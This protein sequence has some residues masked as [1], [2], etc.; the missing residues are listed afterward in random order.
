MAEFYVK[1]SLGNLTV[2]FNISLRYFVIKGEE[3][4]HLWTLEIGTTHE[5][6]N[7]N[8][9]S[10]KK[11][12]NIS[13]GNLD[14][15]IEGALADLCSQIDWSPLVADKRAPFVDNFSPS[16]SSVPITSNVEIII[17]DKLPSAGIDLSNMKIILNNS[18]QDFDI[19]SEVEV[20]DAYYNEY[21]LRWITPLKVYDTYD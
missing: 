9:I 13:A 2:K 4:E 3:G 1:N 20:V 12:H 7:G 18:D 16:G 6:I 14:E 21:R 19:T 17:K 15:V 5:D 11:I 8:D 10:A